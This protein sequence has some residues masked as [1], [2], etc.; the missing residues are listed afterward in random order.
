MKIKWILP[1]HITRDMDV[2]SISQL[3]FA[4]EVVDC[5]TVEALSYKVARKEFILDKEQ[6]YL[7]ITL[8]S[9]HD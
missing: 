9:Q 6:T 1:D 5:V 8:Q 7:A 3:L 2:P 4:L